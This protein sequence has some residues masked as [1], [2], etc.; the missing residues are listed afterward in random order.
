MKIEDID[1]LQEFTPEQWNWILTHNPKDN[2]LLNL[3]SHE[4]YTAMCDAEIH[5]FKE[6]S[7]KTPQDDNAFQSFGGNG[8]VYAG[9]RVGIH[10]I[11]TVTR[12]VTFVITISWGRYWPVK[13]VSD[14]GGIELGFLNEDIG[15]FVYECS[16]YTF[17]RYMVWNIIRYS[18][19]TKEVYAC[20]R[21]TPMKFLFTNIVNSVWYNNNFALPQSLVIV[22]NPKILTLK[23]IDD[24]RKQSQIILTKKLYYL[25]F[26]SFLLHTHPRLGENSPANVLCLDTL[27]LIYKQLI[28]TTE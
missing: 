17:Y 5:L 26:Q 10:C 20:M 21:D 6:G 22:M 19:F 1:L 3:K 16:V 15:S 4:E 13:E 28:N 14:S 18:T 27:E 8:N 12:T 11:V 23:Y 2:P 7:K 24:K 25:L 9:S